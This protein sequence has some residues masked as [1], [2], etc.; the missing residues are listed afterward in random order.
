MKQRVL[1]TGAAGFVGSHLVS[2]VLPTKSYE[3]IGLDNFS[4]PYGGGHCKRRAES[5]LSKFGFEVD[6]VDLSTCSGND[7]LS[8]YG[9]FD[10]VVHLAA[11][12]GVR[13]GQ[14]SPNEYYKN[15]VIAFGNILEYVN[16][17]KPTK[18]LF[19]SSS[20][21]YGDLGET[22]PVT[23]DSADGM[24]LKSFYAATKWSNEILAESH[25]EISG[26]PT[27]ALRFFTFYGPDGRPDM[28]YWK[29]LDS[30]LLDEEI[31]LFGLDGGIRNFTFIDDA[32]QMLRELLK[33]DFTGYQ[34]IN[35]ASS[36][37]IT[38]LQLLEVLG[39]RL[40]SIPRY[41]TAERPLFDASV[42]HADTSY[43]KSLI[44]NYCES[45]ISAGINSFVDWYMNSYRLPATKFKEI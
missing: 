2:A 42:T 28:A 23:E 16:L 11:W 25:H 27:V 21:V 20:S 10:I 44:G 29:F 32:V 7:L 4:A 24:N 38:T 13:F 12:P 8:A 35:I 33:I 39:N 34:P 30:I 9:K 41:R 15:N 26:V 14:L 36:S 37:P 3:V 19:A 31:E 6:F 17:A 40:G 18:F 22:G 43:L 1:I 45:G 5:L